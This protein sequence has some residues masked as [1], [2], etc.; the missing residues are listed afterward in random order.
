MLAPSTDLSFLITVHEQPNATLVQARFPAQHTVIGLSNDSQPVIRNN[1][2]SGL[3]ITQEH[4]SVQWATISNN[5]GAGIA[6]DA[7][8]TTAP[9]V[10]DIAAMPPLNLRIGM[11]QQSPP[12]MRSTSTNTG[13]N[14]S[15]HTNTSPNGR[16]YGARVDNTSSVLVE[17][18]GGDGISILRR[19]GVVIASVTVRYN[20]Q[21]G[22][23]VDVDFGS[24]GDH[25]HGGLNLSSSSSTAIS[26]LNSHIYCNGDDQVWAS[27]ED[28]YIEWNTIGTADGRCVS[29][30]FGIFVDSSILVVDYAASHDGHTSTVVANNY[31]SH[32]VYGSVRGSTDLIL[33]SSRV[34]GNMWDNVGGG[35][36][37][38]K[39]CSC[40]ADLLD[41]PMTTQTKIVPVGTVVPPSPA[42]AVPEAL[43]PSTVVCTLT[44]DANTAALNEIINVIT[45]QGSVGHGLAGREGSVPPCTNRISK[46]FPHFRFYE[47]AP[48]PQCAL[49][50]KTQG[51]NFCE[52]RSN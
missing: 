11:V 10:E 18:N 26:I 33:N 1:K 22:V 38:C 51:Y 21:H 35:F 48:L 3:L 19:R 32:I 25:A 7:Y 39:C 42:P 29:G 44:L 6:A 37:A 43:L 49:P 20:A 30:G 12:N 47:V 52:W 13:T 9:S 36:D 27:T 17:H 16:P 2:I 45:A 23:H 50:Y 28:L 14:A 46:L 4:V 5:L 24:K 41:S 8:T 40:S 31:F 15:T 34:R